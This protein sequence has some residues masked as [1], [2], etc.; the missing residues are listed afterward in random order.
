MLKVIDEG[1]LWGGLGGVN[2]SESL[3]AYF[4]V[5]R[6]PSRAAV[7]NG[8]NRTATSARRSLSTRVIVHQIFFLMAV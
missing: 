1:S 8:H 7:W 5:F 6:K 2:K 3:S 4:P